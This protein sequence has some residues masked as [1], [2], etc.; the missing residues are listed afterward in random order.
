MS[1][2]M[3]HITVKRPS[4]VSLLQKD[5]LRHE[6]DDGTFLSLGDLLRSQAVASVIGDGSINDCPTV[7]ALPSIENQEKI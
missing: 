2:N 5:S 3:R 6:G 4:V 7:N 1:L